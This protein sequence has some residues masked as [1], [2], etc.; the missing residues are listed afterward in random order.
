MGLRTGLVW[1]NF[2]MTSYNPRLSITRMI[3][4]R[5]IHIVYDAK[6]HPRLNIIRGENS[7]GKSTILDFLFYG[8]GGDL[9]DWR[10]AALA[11]SEVLL[12]VTLNGHPAVFAREISETS[13]RP[14]RIF[15][16]SFEEAES[17]TSAWSLHPY[18]RSPNKESF[19]QVIFRLLGMPEAT[20]DANSN[21]TMHQVL[22]LLYADQLSPVDR[23]FKFERFDTALTRQTVGDLLCGAYDNALYRSQLRFREADKELATATAEWRSAIA[24]FSGSEHSVTLEWVQAERAILQAKLQETHAEA[25]ALEERIFHAEVSDGLTIEEQR[26]AYKQV[27]EAQQILLALQSEQDALQMEMLDSDKFIGALE[28]KI[29]QLRDAKATAE[30][31]KGISF[32]YCPSCFAPIEDKHSAHACA[33]CKSPFD[34]GRAQ[35]RILSVINETGIQIRQ[36]KSLQNERKAELSK[37]ELEIGKANRAWAGF[38]ERYR[39]L[40]RVPST[41]LRAKARELYGRAGYLERQI[42]DLGRKTT[43]IERIDSLAQAKNALNSEILK[44][45]DAIEAAERWQQEH[46]RKAYTQIS[47]NTAEFLRND[48]LR[49]DTFSKAESISFSFGDDRLAVNGESFFSASSMVY[50][51]NSFYAGFLKAA[52]ENPAFRHPRLLIMDTV[53]DKGMEPMRSHHFQNLLA[54]LSEAAAADH[55]LIYATAMIAPELE[56]SAHVVDRFYTHEHRTLALP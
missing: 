11:C 12:E 34:Q 53:E 1:G 37:L 50:L 45:K 9:S 35:A 15:L 39:L 51:R 20:G 55:Q 5:E 47:E 27:T 2:A 7:S 4:K 42:E 33:L 52:I 14:M 54:Q 26:N 36:S 44:L 38:A 48:L 24:A 32:I 29:D 25:E 30:T 41:E 6:F 43:I 19:S 16:G 31:L 8:L 21:I 10:E 40:N 18:R 23:I 56:N 22:R 3:V 17:E 46:L 13:G 49:Q 28:A